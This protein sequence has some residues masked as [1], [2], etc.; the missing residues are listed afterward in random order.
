MDKFFSNFMN[1]L[2]VFL[3]VMDCETN[4]FVYCNKMAEN[5]LNKMPDKDKFDF[6]KEIISKGSLSTHFESLEGEGEHWFYMETVK[7]EWLDAKECVIILGSD[8]SDYIFNENIISTEAYIDKLTGLSN[9]KIGI[10]MLNKFIAEQKTTNVPFTAAFVDLDNL[11]YVNDNFSRDEGDN[12]I[13]TVVDLITKS[14]RKSD[15]FV[16]MGGDDF[17]LIFPTCKIH[18]VNTILQEVSNRLKSIGNSPAKS[19]FAINY[20]V[21]EINAEDERTTPDVLDE[22]DKIMLNMQKSR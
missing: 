11:N 17:L 15:I 12:Y 19:H 20:G 6:I 5:C 9:Q 3:C 4:D 21:L 14:I 18:V 16:R 13:L 8:Q 2:P 22:L 10:K 1:A 7:F